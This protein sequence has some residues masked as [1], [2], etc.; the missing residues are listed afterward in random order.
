MVGCSSVGQSAF[1]FFWF[2]FL[3]GVVMSSA[4]V[5]QSFILHVAYASHGAH[6]L[7][8][9]TP[10][11]LSLPHTHTHRVFPSTPNL[12]HLSGYHENTHTHSEVVLSLL[13]HFHSPTFIFTLSFPPPF[14]HS[15]FLPLSPPFPSPP[16]PNARYNVSHCKD[17]CAHHNFQSH[18]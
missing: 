5:A 13:S 3:V 12:I 9:L 17:L 6:S 16:P 4:K 1:Y 14:S 2:V 11:S 10:L 7:P 18:T 15:H 8:L